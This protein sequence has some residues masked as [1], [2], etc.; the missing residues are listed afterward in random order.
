MINKAISFA[1]LAHS[2]QKRKGTDIPY[3]LHPLEAGIIVSQIKY[4]EDLI[5]AAILHDTAEDAKVGYETIAEI[6][7][8][9]LWEKTLL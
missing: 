5:C 3:I 9:K 8:A 1:C 2:K 6:F 4:D 7:Y